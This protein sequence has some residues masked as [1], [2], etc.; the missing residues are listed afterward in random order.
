VLWF[1]LQTWSELCCGLG[2]LAGL[3]CLLIL[4]ACLPV[5][6]PARDFMDGECDSRDKETEFDFVM[7]GV[8]LFC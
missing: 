3:A 5:W 7:Q 1:G 8:Y 2:W 6:L 4:S